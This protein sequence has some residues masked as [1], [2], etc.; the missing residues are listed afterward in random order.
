MTMEEEKK[1]ETTEEVADLAPTEPENKN[2]KW[3]VA[4]TN[5]GYENKVAVALKQRVEAS[6]MGDKIVNI[7]VP[8]QEKIMVESGRK[9]TIDE[10]LFPGYV[11]LK[12]EMDDFTWNIVRNTT[13]VTGFVGT[14]NK[15]SALPEKEAASILKFMKMQ[16]PKF[17]AK[18]N[19]GDGVKIIKGP[20]SDFMGK[21]EG[22][23]DEKGTV[24][25]LVSVFGRETP[26]E[27]DF[28]QVNPL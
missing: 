24:V 19:I 13:G 1:E 27:L 3:Y 15:P 5:A 26:V 17:E 8:T 10:K 22:I 2:L 14:G 18:F 28:S 9:K 7:L 21:V 23:N 11:L 16:A 20:F 6:G 4:H 25:V 12:M